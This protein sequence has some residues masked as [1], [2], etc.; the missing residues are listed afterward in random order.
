MLKLRKKLNQFNSKKKLNKKIMKRRS[1]LKLTNNSKLQTNK[2]TMI[3]KSTLKVLLIKCKKQEMKS[4]RM[5]RVKS[6]TL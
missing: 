4:Q 6:K 1:Q 3:N 5:K 2:K